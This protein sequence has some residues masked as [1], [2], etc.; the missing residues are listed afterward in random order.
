MA[1]IDIVFSILIA[2]HK[3]LITDRKRNAYILNRFWIL[4]KSSE[5]LIFVSDKILR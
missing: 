2:N 5:I 3:F 4:I 1:I